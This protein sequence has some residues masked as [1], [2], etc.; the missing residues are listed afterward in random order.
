MNYNTDFYKN[1][2]GHPDVTNISL[3]EQNLTKISEEDVKKLTKPFS[4]QEIKEVV[5]GM[6]IN[7][8]PCR[9]GFPADFHHDL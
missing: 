4:L 6:R 3:T 9:D 1:L 7:K 5:L 2:F 8:S